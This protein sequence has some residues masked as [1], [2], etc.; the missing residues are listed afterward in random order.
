MS[1]RPRITR[2]LEC[3]SSRQVMPDGRPGIPAPAEIGRHSD[4]CELRSGGPTLVQ[5]LQEDVALA[6]ITRPEGVTS[7]QGDGVAGYDTPTSVIP[8]TSGLRVKK[9]GRTTGRTS[10]AV[11]AL[12]PDFLAI[13][14]KC[15]FFNATV[16]FRRVWTVRADPGDTFAQPGDSGSLVV[17]EDG[18]GAIGLVFAA[19]VPYGDL[20]YIIP[21]NHVEGLLGGL[22]L[23]AGHGI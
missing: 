2:R 21:M 5:P 16:W 11:E 6:R 12:I 17:T 14:Y 4:I 8:P 19:S 10:G 13:P 9:F 18:A 20:G 22:D 7:W 23:V 1:L 3:Q 15:R